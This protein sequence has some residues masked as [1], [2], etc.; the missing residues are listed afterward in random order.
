MQIP[1]RKPGKYANQE[2]D[3]HLTQEKVD[4][5]KAEL[6]RLK[7]VSRPRAASEV[8]RLAEMG[9]F[10]E[11]AAY[12]MA[13]GRLRGIN[14]RILELDDHLKRAVIIRPDSSGVVQLGSTVTVE[15]SGK[16]KMFLILGSTETDPAAGV[17]S[18][19]SPIGAALMGHRVGDTVS[20]LLANRKAVVCTIVRVA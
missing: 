8:K 5:M 16:Q 11:N 12:Q 6:E 18:H 10:S 1:K 15:I 7:F 3:P 4:E 19:K 20:F 14:Q 2:R 9:D 17:I 13:K